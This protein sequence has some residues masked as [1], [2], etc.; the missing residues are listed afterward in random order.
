MKTL[1]L[2]GL[3]AFCFGYGCHVACDTGIINETDDSEL[4]VSP[5]EPSVKEKPGKV[6][7]APKNDKVIP[8]ATLDQNLMV[9]I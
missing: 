4:Q 2:L 7:Q 1:I 9:N 5:P 3:L 6:N 8:G